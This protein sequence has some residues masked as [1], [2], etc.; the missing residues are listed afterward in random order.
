MISVNLASD[1]REAGTSGARPS[2][3]TLNIGALRL[4]EP[5]SASDLPMA[6]MWS[7]T[8]Q[9][10]AA[11]LVASVDALRPSLGTN[12]LLVGRLGIGG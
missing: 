9:A 3:S 12:I 2:I 6:S 8:S 10:R 11:D 4:D 7:P 1:L 5:E